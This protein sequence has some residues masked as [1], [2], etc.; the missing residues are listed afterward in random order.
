M[1]ALLLTY[2]GDAGLR[3]P[4][5]EVGLPGAKGAKRDQGAKAIIL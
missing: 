4:V 2:S 3:G 1:P 5:G